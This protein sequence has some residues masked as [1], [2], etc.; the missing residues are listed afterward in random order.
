[1]SNPIVKSQRVLNRFSDYADTYTRVH[2]V[3]V[4]TLPDGAG[5]KASI[6]TPQR[7][8]ERTHARAD[9]A[10]QF[11]QQDVRNAE[12]AGEVFPTK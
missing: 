6:E 11:V 12:Q 10:A 5:Y 7:T 9:K 2:R 3:K 4:Q 8:F 1:M